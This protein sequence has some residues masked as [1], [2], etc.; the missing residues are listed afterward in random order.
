MVAAFSVG[1][2]LTFVGIGLA[3]VWGTG[4][5][6]KSFPGFDRLAQRLPYLSAGLVMAVGVVMTAAGLNAAGV[7]GSQQPK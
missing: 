2:A 7:F 4:K 1:L 6:T 5:L 3:V